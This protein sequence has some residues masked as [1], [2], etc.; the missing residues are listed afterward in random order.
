MYK[1]QAP[2]S[3]IQGPGVLDNLA[4]YVKG[5]GSN[6]LILSGRTALKQKK[7]AIEGSFATA[8]I[9]CAFEECVEGCTINEINR[10]ADILKEGKFDC[11]IGLGA[12]KVMDTA[13]AAGYQAGLPY[14]TAPSAASSDAPCSSLAII[15]NSEG[16]VSEVRVLPTNPHLVIVDSQLIANAPVKMLA[17][18]MGDALATYFEARVCYENNYDNA[19]GSKISLTGFHLAHLCYK[20]L[21]EYGVSA[22]K[23]VEQREVTD[24]LEYIIEANTYLSS[25]GFECGGLSCAHSIQDALSAIPECRNYSHGDRV[26]FGTLCLLVMENRPQK[27]IEELL[28]FC[29][30]VGLPVTLKQIGLEDDVEN[31]L[32]KVLHIAYDE[33]HPTCRIPPGVTPESLLD[34]VKKA[35]ELG[36]NY[37]K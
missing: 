13:K 24:E 10:V 30:K 6:F 27:E 19:I 36:T 32:K 12:G 4:G 18:G 8:G 16:E 23:A 33:N 5:I 2:F 9:L 25:V 14:I 21:I 3:Y 31:K 28:D 1:I 17:D 20:T 34:S 11:I 7:S 37:L 26:A 22:K 15:Y 35:D 29:T